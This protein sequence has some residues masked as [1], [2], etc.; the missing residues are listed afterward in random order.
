MI[1]VS[2]DSSLLVTA[3]SMATT[4]LCK[5]GGKSGGLFSS[6]FL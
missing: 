1:P 5:S 3:G 2:S 6:I 4:I